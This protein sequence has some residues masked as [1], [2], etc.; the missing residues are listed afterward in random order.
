MPR[1]ITLEHKTGFDETRR[2]IREFRV[3]RKYR[4]S[5]QVKYANERFLVVSNNA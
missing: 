4:T 2:W 1:L 5:L 3:E